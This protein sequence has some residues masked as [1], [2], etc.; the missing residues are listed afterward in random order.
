M[1]PREGIE[2][3][4][5]LLKDLIMNQDGVETGYATPSRLGA[6]ADGWIGE[7]RQVIP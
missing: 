1:S 6:W 7:R 4:A 5:R 2:F 3:A